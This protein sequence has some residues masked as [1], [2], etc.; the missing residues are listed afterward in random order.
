[1]PAAFGTADLKSHSMD[2]SAKASGELLG[3]VVPCPPMHE[4]A[5]RHAVYSRL[6]TSLFGFTLRCDAD[7][8]ACAAHWRRGGSA[9]IRMLR[10]DIQRTNLPLCGHQYSK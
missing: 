2:V 8:L 9:A 10:A 7:W 4:S 1:M 6:A 5:D 3:S